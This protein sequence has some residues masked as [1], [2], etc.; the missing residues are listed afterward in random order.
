[1]EIIKVLCRRA[2]PLEPP[3]PPA[4]RPATNHYKLINKLMLYDVI[5]FWGKNR[6][7]EEEE[8]ED[9]DEEEEET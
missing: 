6:G 5:V 7:S 4:S 3:V 2:L 9:E 8:E 1:M